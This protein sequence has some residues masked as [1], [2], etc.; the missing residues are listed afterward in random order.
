MKNEGIWDLVKK[1]KQDHLMYHYQNL[2]DEE[3][4]ELLRQLESIDWTLLDLLKDKDKKV[5]KGLIEPIEVLEID[6]IT[7]NI[8]VYNE[9]GVKAIQANKLGLVLLAGG[10]GT[11][12]GYNQAKGTLNVGVTKDL[13]IYELLIH[14][15]MEVTQRAKCWIPL[16]IMTSDRTHRETVEFLS[17]HQYFGYNQEYV[18][19]F[20]Q[21]MSPSVDYT[22]KIYM[23]SPSQIALSP[24]GNGGWFQSL[25]NAGLLAQIHQQ[26]VEWLNV[27]SVDNV[28]Q[29]IADP[30]F[31]GATILSGKD[32]G[33]KVVKKASEDERVGVICLEDGR[34]SIIEYYEATKE[35]QLVR[36]E[37]GSLVYNFGVILNYL[38]HVS[39]LEKIKDSLPTHLV[40]RKIPYIDE[41]NEYINPEEP[42][43]YKYETLVLDMVH[44]MNGCL[45]YEV[46]REKEFAPIKNKEGVD[47]L[48]TARELLRKN[49]IEL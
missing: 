20:Q 29:R 11:R 26:G 25:V 16:Y 24:N 15:L 4:G 47:S 18:C 40:E 9:I 41:K 2:K 22:G 39:A 27:F 49:G 19:F 6:E 1:Y 46:E 17:K 28:L 31:L 3:K 42:N 13:Y 14:N 7:E 32:C 8:K 48:V 36:D 43:G 33:T 23:T 35:M 37:K 45:P 38:F 12:L 10:Q 5:E 44:L 30:A 34:P 21:E